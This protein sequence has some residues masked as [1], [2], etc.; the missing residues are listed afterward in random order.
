LS[1]GVSSSLRHLPLSVHLAAIDRQP[2]GG[3]QENAHC[4][5]NQDDSLAAFATR[6]DGGAFQYT[7]IPCAALPSR[8]LFEKYDVNGS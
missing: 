6:I 2:E 3:D 4:H 8:T 1:G 7:M 5:Y